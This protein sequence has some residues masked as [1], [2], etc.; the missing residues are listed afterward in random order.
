ML[1]IQFIIDA[2]NRALNYDRE[3]KPFPAARARTHTHTH[4]HTGTLTNPRVGVGLCIV[5]S[6]RSKCAKRS[7]EKSSNQTRQ[8]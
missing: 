5:D 2:V 3:N 4:T 8:L 7:C 6:A 1:S